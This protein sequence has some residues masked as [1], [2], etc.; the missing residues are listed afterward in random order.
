MEKEIKRLKH[1]AQKSHVEYLAMKKDR[2]IRK[3]FSSFI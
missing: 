1:E 3:V 2:K